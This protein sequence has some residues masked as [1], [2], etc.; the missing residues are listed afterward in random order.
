MTFENFTQW[1]IGAEPVLEGYDLILRVSKDGADAFSLVV[2]FKSRSSSAPEL[3]PQVFKGTRAE[4]GDILNGT[5][6]ELP[7]QIMDLGERY[8]QWK[9]AFAEKSDTPALAAEKKPRVKKD[10]PVPQAGM[11]K[12]KFNV[13]LTAV[14][15]GVKSVEEAK[16]ENMDMS[17]QQLQELSLSAPTKTA[18]PAA[19]PPAPTVTEAPD[20]DLPQTA[21]PESVDEQAIRICGEVEKLFDAGSID[22]VKKRWPEVKD[23]KNN[24]GITELGLR[25]IIALHQKMS[26]K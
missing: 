9:E 7:V 17:V 10:A 23:L 12:D 13:V 1:L 20:L 24:P 2:T 5:A 19:E 6:Q 21:S 25:H 3:Q 16:M 22:E 18:V 15:Q 26:G 4:I 14:K 11:N 8:A